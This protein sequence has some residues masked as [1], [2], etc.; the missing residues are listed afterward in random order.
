VHT[1]FLLLSPSTPTHLQL[2]ARIAFSL[3]TPGFDQFL[4]TRPD[5]TELVSHLQRLSRQG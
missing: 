1:V 2:L 4:A 5:Q 3:R